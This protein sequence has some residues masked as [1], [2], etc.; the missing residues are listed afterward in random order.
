[1]A[2]PRSPFKTALVKANNAIFANAAEKR[3]RTAETSDNSFVDVQ[4]STP[5]FRS[6][7][8]MSDAGY[9][10]PIAVGNSLTRHATSGTYR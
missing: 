6:I 10:N 7:Q 4:P 2:L 8:G 1:M 5:A 9:A 3:I